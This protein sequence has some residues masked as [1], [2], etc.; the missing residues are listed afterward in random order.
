MLDTRT[1]WFITKRP[2]TS[3]LTNNISLTFFPYIFINSRFLFFYSSQCFSI[4]KEFFQIS[5]LRK[6]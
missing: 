2:K 4:P 6:T 5:N 1:L 3:G